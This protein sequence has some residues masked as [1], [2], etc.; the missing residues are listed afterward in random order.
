MANTHK[1]ESVVTIGG[2][3]KKLRFDY[4]AIADLEDLRDRSLTAL[5][6]D[7]GE[8]NMRFGFI[9]DA[10]YC[11]ML[12]SNRGKKGFTKHSIGKLMVADEMQGYAV[13][14]SRALMAAMGV[15]DAAVEKAINEAGAD[16][17]APDPTETKSDGTG[18]SFNE[19][20]LLVDSSPTNSGV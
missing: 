16:G 17:E 9:R 8:G 7:L 18:E 2:H 6:E 12:W 10:L 4:N 1:G 13:A 14:L 15:D 19:P 20:L 11:G 3:E 5:L